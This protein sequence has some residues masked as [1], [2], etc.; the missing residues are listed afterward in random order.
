MSSQ[1][2]LV[3]FSSVVF[4]VK[5][6]VSQSL[7]C[8]GRVL[9]ERRTDDVVVGVDLA[10]LEHGVRRSWGQVVVVGRKGRTRHGGAR[11]PERRTKVPR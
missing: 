4:A 9:A 8:A 6:V 3:R 5:S 2:S 10:A 11:T 7:R 1:F